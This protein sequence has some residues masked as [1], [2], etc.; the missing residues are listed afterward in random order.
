[1]FEIHAWKYWSS[2]R[3]IDRCTNRCNIRL[4]SLT[5]SLLLRSSP[6][7]LRL[8]KNFSFDWNKYNFFFFLRYY[9]F[10]TRSLFICY[11]LKKKK[12]KIFVEMLKYF[13]R[14]MYVFESCPRATCTILTRQLVHRKHSDGRELHSE[15][16]KP[17]RR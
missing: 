13:R 3:V 10:I 1:M 8:N 16:V 17:H 7:E 14:K 5:L 12:R 11:C 15:W 9:L 6:V 2:A 4:C